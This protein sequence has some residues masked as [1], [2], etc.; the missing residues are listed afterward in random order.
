MS[1]VVVPFVP[2][3]VVTVTL[4]SPMKTF[5]K[6]ESGREMA[7]QINAQTSNKCAPAIPV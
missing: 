4:P 5:R 6:I 1:Y 2:T 7:R 3:S